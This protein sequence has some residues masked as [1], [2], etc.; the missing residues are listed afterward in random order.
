MMPAAVRLPHLVGT[1]LV[2]RALGAA[3]AALLAIDAA[4]HLNDAHL[5]DTGAGGIT[6]GS[7]FRVEAGVALAVAVA[8]L[9]RPHWSVWLIALL[10]AASPAGA[11]YLYT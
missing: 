5:Y 6:E 7:L 3:T 9:V 8:L 4:V 1:S 11:L 2:I 10:V